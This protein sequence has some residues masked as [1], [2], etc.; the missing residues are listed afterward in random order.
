[1]KKLIIFIVLIAFI[2]FGAVNAQTKKSATKSKAK[3]EQVKK[4]AKPE[5]VKK[6]AKTVKE[7]KEAKTD[8]KVTVEKKEVKATTGKKAVKEQKASAKP[9]SADKVIRG[10]KGP[11]GQAVY[12]GARGGEYYINKN[13]NK[14]YLK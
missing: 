3:T 8:K 9:E 14:T 7:K 10:K 5:Q 2:S 12:K 1:M 6:D 13:G 11:D 4:D